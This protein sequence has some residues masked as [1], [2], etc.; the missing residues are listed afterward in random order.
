MLKIPLQ[1]PSSSNRVRNSWMQAPRWQ[2][3]VVHLPLAGKQLQ[4]RSV[5]ISLTKQRNWNVCRTPM[6]LLYPPQSM[7]IQ[8]QV[9]PFCQPP[10]VWLSCRTASISRVVFLDNL[11]KFPSLLEQTTTRWDIRYVFWLC[12]LSQ[13]TTLV[14]SYANGATG[15]APILTLLS[16]TCPAAVVAGDRT[17]SSLPAWQCNTF[18]RRHN[19]WLIVNRSLLW[20]VAKHHTSKLDLAVI[21]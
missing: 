5:A 12:W 6:A 7:R 8:A 14:S 1:E 4:P 15:L 3:T 21:P 20:N 2:S 16:F 10:M 11:P 9:L 17:N 19:S 13:G 18:L